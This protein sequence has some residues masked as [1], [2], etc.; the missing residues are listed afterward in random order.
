MFSIVTAI[1]DG[2]EYFRKTIPSV[3]DQSNTDWEW[4][5]VD[6]GN[7][8]KLEKSFPE[9]TNKRIRIF[10]F[11]ESIGQTKSLNFG[12]Q[13][14][15]FDWIVRVDGDDLCELDRIQELGKQDLARKRLIFSDYAVIDED[16][17][18]F[19]NI[20]Y[21]H[22]LEEGFFK[23]LKFKNNPICHPTVSFYKWDQS[24][25]LRLYDERL[26]NAQDYE[27]W[28]RILAE[29]GEE[30]FGH[31]PKELLQYRVVAESLSG[32]RIKEQQA[33]LK[34]IRTGVR[35][36]KNMA[37]LNVKEK[38]AMQA[39]RKLY[40]SFLSSSETNRVDLF[41]SLLD[42]SAY[43]RYFFRSLFFVLFFPFRK[44]VMK[45]IFNGI[46]S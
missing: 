3:L 21:T 5:I 10:R 19:A 29:E 18:I 28:K 43:Y 40:Y 6:D 32:K 7:S 26:R 33:E 14:S 24:R 35:V 9:L 15:R 39:Y 37:E 17:K 2:F 44:K 11:N 46:F 25:K 8:S 41:S 20:R 45:N 12:I 1:K 16:G 13:Q 4:I 42:A 23:Y 36:Q 22:P 30:S 34:S 38:I 31:I 27:L